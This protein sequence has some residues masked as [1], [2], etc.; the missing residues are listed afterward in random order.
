MD[1]CLSPDGVYNARITDGEFG[2]SLVVLNKPNAISPPQ[3]TQCTCAPPTSTSRVNR[4]E[5]TFFPGTRS[6]PN[7]PPRAIQ[8]S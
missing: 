1:I 2:G 4:W 7:P 3:L 5:R 8:S 6:G